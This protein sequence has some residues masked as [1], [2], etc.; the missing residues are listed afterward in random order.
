MFLDFAAFAVVTIF[1]VW[2]W[3]L[4]VNGRT[5]L[6]FWGGDDKRFFKFG[7][8]KVRDNLFM[9]FGTYRL[10]RIFSPSLRTL[11]LSG[12]EW[13]FACFDQGYDFNGIKLRN[14]DQESISTM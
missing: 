13:S 8:D 4:C 11:P 2:S 5:T 7:F 9:T 6:E 1:N 3:Y 14:A 10:F 12:I